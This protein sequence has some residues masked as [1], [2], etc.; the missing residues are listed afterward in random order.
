MAA[1]LL[2]QSQGYLPYYLIYSG[3]SA[4]LHSVA[5][6]RMEPASALKAFSGPA[7][8]EPTGLLARVYAT[9][10]LY[11]SLIRLYAAYH[12]T[13]NP[14][15]YD[16]AAWTF[17]GVLWLYGS[18]LAVY[19]TVRMREASFPFVTAGVGLVWMLVQRDWYRGL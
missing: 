16:L 11:T 8:P 6:Y 4:V 13:N 14:Q 19:K 2:P 18:E 15:L 12:L 3:V 9:K 7:R 10:N 5:C 17:A 1:A